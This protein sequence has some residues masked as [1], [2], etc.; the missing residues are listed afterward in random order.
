MGWSRWSCGWSI[1]FRGVLPQSPTARTSPCRA[2]WCSPA[3]GSLRCPRWWCR[4]WNLVLKPSEIF[5]V[6]WWLRFDVPGKRRSKSGTLPP[7]Q[8]QRVQVPNMR[9]MALQGNAGGSKQKH[10]EG[11]GDEFSGHR[12]CMCL[13]LRQGPLPPILNGHTVISPSP[14]IP[15]CPLAGHPR[16]SSPKSSASTGHVPPCDVKLP[17]AW[18]S[19]PCQ[20]RVQEPRIGAKM[21]L[22]LSATSSLSLNLN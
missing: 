16:I 15:G 14:Q 6:S 22:R 8:T 5:R 12:R 17:K 11:L 19:A 20:L 4:T 13:G 7:S 9:S 2:A 18:V 10:V 3:S 21:L 1:F